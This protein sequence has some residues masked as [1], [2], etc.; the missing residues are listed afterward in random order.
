MRHFACNEKEKNAAIALN[1][2]IVLF[3]QEQKTKLE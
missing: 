2:D 3:A 1:K